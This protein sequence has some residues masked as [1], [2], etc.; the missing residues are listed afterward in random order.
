MRRFVIAL[1][2]VLLATAAAA[3]TPAGKP[4]THPAK[5]TTTMQMD[6]DH[7][8]VT[9][10]DGGVQSRFAVA[11]G[12]LEYDPAR[13]DRS[14]L[15][16]SLDAGSLTDAATAQLFD[17]QH[18]PEMR[19]ASTASG[20]NNGDTETLATDVTIRDVT[21][22]VVFHLRLQNVSAGVIN[23]HAEATIR[24]ADFH[25]PGK[26]GDI[27]LVIDAPFDAVQPTRALP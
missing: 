8:N 5:T 11:A 9:V 10:R 6:S 2:L 1:G 12:A 13:P 25:V 26:G 24:G 15:A 7:A 14:T 23:L 27:V 16:M 18:F 20:K 19:I 4:E 22:P 21:R 3:Q 17:A